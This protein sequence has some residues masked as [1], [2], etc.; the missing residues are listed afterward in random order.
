MSSL[1]GLPPLPKS[2]SGF[3][4]NEN[5]IDPPTPARTTSMRSH[6]GLQSSL[7]SNSMLQQPHKGMNG[8]SE[9]SPSFT[10]GRKT[11]NLD[12]QLAILRREMVS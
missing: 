10:P 7:G 5:Y 8:T 11:S 3:N 9:L 2:L 4:L 6:Q 1:H 12:S